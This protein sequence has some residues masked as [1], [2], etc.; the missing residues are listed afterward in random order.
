MLYCVEILDFGNI[1]VLKCISLFDFSKQ[2]FIFF[3]VFY[4]VEKVYLNDCGDG[5]FDLSLTFTFLLLLFLSWRLLP[6]WKISPCLIRLAMH[7]LVQF[8]PELQSFQFDASQLQTMI[9]SGQVWML[10]QFG[11]LCTE[12]TIRHWKNH[13]FSI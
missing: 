9:D 4:W 2:I 10:I 6:L 13:K 5:W 12:S 1:S 3:F 7:I 8:T 11:S